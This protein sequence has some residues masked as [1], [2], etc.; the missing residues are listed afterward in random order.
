MSY[1]RAFARR[2]LGFIDADRQNIRFRWLEIANSFGF[3][4]KIINWK[5]EGK[6]S[7]NIRLIWPNIYLDI[8]FVRRKVKSDDMLEAWGVSTFDQS[9][10]INW[11]DWCT[12][13]RFPWSYQWYATGY[14]MKSGYWF[15]RFHFNNRDETI[16]RIWDWIERNN[17]EQSTT[18][19]YVY[20]LESGEL[21]RRYATIKHRKT[22][23]R[24]IAFMWTD[25][26]AK[27]RDYIDVRFDG[28]VGERTGSW[29]GGC[30]GCSYDMKKGETPL[31]T[32]RR[33]EVERK[34]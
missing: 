20:T 11:G 33:M 34:F 3:S 25:L 28:E 7:L 32:L 27:K 26:F 31:D 10:Q 12:F 5:E 4:L 8:P 16:K 6:F 2:Y 21:Q 1:L 17:R 24:P 14:L 22:E 30:I 9:L 15:Y 23:Y 29:K 19:E 18:H 13:I